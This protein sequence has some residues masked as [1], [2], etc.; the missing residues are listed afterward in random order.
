MGGL[1][2]SLEAMDESV[3]SSEKA[4]SLW[5]PVGDV[6]LENLDAEFLLTT[7]R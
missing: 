4:T 3:T 2:A 6:L 1:E 5:L 7:V